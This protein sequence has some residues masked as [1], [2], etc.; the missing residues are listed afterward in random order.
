MMKAKLFDSHMH[1]ELC[2]HAEGYLWEY[3]DR[4]WKAALDGVIFTCHSPM[5]EGYSPQIR[6]KQDQLW[7]YVALVDEAKDAAPEGFEVRLG[8][9]SD[10]FPGTESWMEK[11]HGAAD[12]HYI[13]GS[14]HWHL[15]EYQAN[16]QRGDMWAFYCQYFEHLAEAAESGLFDCLSHP[17]HVRGASFQDWD[18]TRLRPVIERSLDRIAATGIAMEMN[19]SGYDS[20]FRQV[21]PGIEMLAMMKERGIPVVLGSDAH[22]PQFVASY[23]EPALEVLVEVG[24]DAVSSFENRQR[25]EISIVEAKSQLEEAIVGAV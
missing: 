9:E 12:F 17:D 14:V 10:Y 15:P 25:N 22:Q 6:M 19:T 8:L 1:T 23:F 20:P 2:K 13:L 18:P 21:Y 5:P 24:Y 7:D 4:G 11:L 16:F 3:V